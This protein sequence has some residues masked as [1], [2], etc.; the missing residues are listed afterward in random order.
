MP[1]V[2]VSEIDGI[3]SL[4]DGH[5]RTYAAYERGESHI[6]AVVTDL[7]Q[8]E[9][10]KALYRHIHREG[11]NKGIYTIADLSD[12]IVEPEQHRR[13]WIGT[14]NKWLKDNGQQA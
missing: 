14:C 6:Q 12:R 11:L 9:G 5:A 3:L 7:E 8:I 4:I 10:S 13:Q 1:P 2:L